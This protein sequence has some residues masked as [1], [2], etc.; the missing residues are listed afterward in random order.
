MLEELLVPIDILILFFI[1]ILSQRINR[2]LC[3]NL[4]KKISHMRFYN[5]MRMQ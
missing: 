3:S 5:E 2:V 1:E 4:V